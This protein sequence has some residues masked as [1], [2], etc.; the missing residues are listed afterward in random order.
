M[1]SISTVLATIFDEGG[2]ICEHA[3]RFTDGEIYRLINR[4]TGHAISSIPTD[5][6]PLQSITKAIAVDRAFPGTREENSQVRINILTRVMS[7]ADYFLDME[8]FTS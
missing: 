3:F 6:T 4:A 1:S 5:G 8:I 2:D 7:F